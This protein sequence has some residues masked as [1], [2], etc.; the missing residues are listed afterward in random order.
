M[1]I[2]ECLH[3]QHPHHLP[4]FAT[5]AASL[6]GNGSSSERCSVIMFAINGVNKTGASVLCCCLCCAHHSVLHMLIVVIHNV[7]TMR[8]HCTCSH[9]TRSSA[10]ATTHTCMTLPAR[11]ACCR[12]SA[13]WSSTASCTLRCS[14]VKMIMHGLFARCICALCRAA[15]QAPTAMHAVLLPLYSCLPPHLCAAVNQ[16]HV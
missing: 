5:A 8:V 2:C 3:L 7:L 13:S 10:S 14:G 4:V 15:A 12:W 16:S 9:T 11:R 1:E 6:P